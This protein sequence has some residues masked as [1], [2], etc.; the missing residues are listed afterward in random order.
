[1]A[2]G[3]ESELWG[4]AKIPQ[5]IL[6]TGYYAHDAA[7]DEVDYV[8]YCISDAEKNTFQYF[9][10]KLVRA[11]GLRTFDARK[12]YS[13]SVGLVG[14]DL[15]HDENFRLPHCGLIGGVCAKPKS[16]PLEF[17]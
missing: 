1:M 2:I 13:A 8:H 11:V 7:R 16:R 5:W 4:S 6:L 15:Q 9:E 14:L 17:M 12:Y 3:Y 10:L